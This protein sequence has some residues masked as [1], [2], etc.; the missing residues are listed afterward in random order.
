MQPGIE[1]VI[2]RQLLY[3]VFLVY[4][5]HEK[6]IL[7]ESVANTK[8]LIKRPIDLSSVVSLLMI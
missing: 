5:L 3:C 8:R 6:W 2:S 7:Y 4:V 1:S